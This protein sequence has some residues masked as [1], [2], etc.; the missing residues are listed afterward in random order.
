MQLSI[1]ADDHDFFEKKNN[2]EEDIVKLIKGTIT[3][4]PDITWASVQ[5]TA[6]KQ[7]SIDRN[8]IIVKRLREIYAD[9]CYGCDVQKRKK[10]ND[11][12]DVRKNILTKIIE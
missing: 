1:Y 6:Q 12:K 2:P 7:Q 10:M 5:K 3:L 8:Q 11:N 4:S 9:D